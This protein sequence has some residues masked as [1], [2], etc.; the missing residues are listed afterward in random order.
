[1]MD[2]V[3]AMI[4][5]YKTWPKQLIKGYKEGIKASH[6]ID[7]IN[8][9]VFCGM[10][11]SGATGDFVRAYLNEEQGI[12]SFVVKEFKL[13][14][15]VGKD[16][17]VFG[18][19]YSG[20]TIETL[21][22]VREAIE[23]GARVITV[24]SGGSLQGLARSNGLQHVVLDKGYYPRTA[25]AQMIGAVLGVLSSLTDGVT[26]NL[27]NEIAERLSRV[28]PGSLKDAAYRLRNSDPI[29]IV[30][31]SSL[32]PLARRF[33]SELSENSKVIA[34][35]EVYPESGH[36]DIV[37][38]QASHNADLGFIIINVKGE[39]LYSIIMDTLKEIYSS[40]GVV[41]E[42][43]LEPASRLSLLI[44]GSLMAGYLS[45]YLAGYR[46]VDPR[47]TNIISAYKE[48]TQKALA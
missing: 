35:E 33:R 39:K 28:K 44:E 45:V 6:V 12:P 47:D 38:W 9:I 43:V 34:K 21:T 30:T 37:S 15:W 4:N 20:N 31:S 48:A 17:L 14:R 27:V 41:E 19:S 13:P 2:P 25:L 10:G 46:N 5:L 3:E 42:L 29:V 40:H 16:T 32:E 11:G 24:S 8:N 7:G 23:R 1:M 26:M 18:I 22:C 36:N